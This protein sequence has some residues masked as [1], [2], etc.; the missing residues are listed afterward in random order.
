MRHMI[1]L[2]LGSLGDRAPAYEI[3][4]LKEHGFDA[5]FTG[6]RSTKQVAD[7]AELCAKEGLIY[8]CIHAP[9]E[10]AADLWKSGEAGNIAEQELKNCLKSCAII[11]VNKMVSHPF[12]GF[13]EHTPVQTGLDRYFRLADCAGKYGIKI[14]IENVEGEEYFDFLMQGL[15][16][17]PN[18]GFC[19]DSGHQLCYNRGRD[20]L[21]EYGDRLF[22]LHINSNM[23]V[24]GNKIT[25]LDDS[26]MLP[27]DGSA[28]MTRL[29]DH[30]HRLHYP[31]V[32]MMELVR[33]NRPG[34]NTNDS[35][36]TMTDDEYL[37]K[38]AAQ[39]NRLR[40]MV[41]DKTE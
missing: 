24:T 26:H 35:Y 2:A 3:H 8:D 29:A 19:F 13:L 11:G 5:T 17:Y 6:W 16:D 32:L 10:K 9:F 4:K 27:F 22:Y 36:L 25:W 18:V 7:F 31:G 41:D 15:R 12:I 40:K 28:D 14:C 20:L 30:L 21:T 1:G 37:A 39:I 34:R 33:G 23:G 38:A